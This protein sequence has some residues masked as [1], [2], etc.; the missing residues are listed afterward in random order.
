MSSGFEEM[1]SRLLRRWLAAGAD[2]PAP[3]PAAAPARVEVPESLTLPGPRMTRP[4][5]GVFMPRH[6]RR[7]RRS[8]HD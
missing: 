6:G 4:V 8:L 3:N 2:K 5:D 1:F 7:R